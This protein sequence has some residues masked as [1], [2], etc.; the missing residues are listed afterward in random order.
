[1]KMA[2]FTLNNMTMLALSL[3]T[4]IVIDDAIVVLENI[5]R[6]VEEKGVSPKEAAADATSGNRPGGDGDDP[7]AGRHLRAG[8][9]HDRPDRPLLLQLRHHL[10]GGDSAL[11]VRLLHA[12]A[13]ALRDVVE[14]GGRQVGSLDH[15]I[16]AASTPSIDDRLRP[17][18]GVVA[19]HRAVMIGDRRRGGDV[20]RMHSIPYVG[21][22][23][24]PD[25]DQGEFSINVRLPRGT[26]YPRT[27]EFIQPIE[28]EVL[29]LPALHR[30][31]AERQLR[32]RATSTS[33]WC[34]SKSGRSHS[35]S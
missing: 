15:Q 26:S 17:D 21:K 8:G 34:R 25:D 18:A 30:V 6:F 11:D 12:D 16:V 23:L 29:A 4:G 7:V 10:G 19:R 32:L 31:D 9:F 1:M 28:K 13:G 3:A 24:V 33:R 27:E 20:G 2:G 35:S 14:A 22:E 5:F